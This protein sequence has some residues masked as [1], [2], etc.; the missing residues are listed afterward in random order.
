[1]EFDEQ[2][3]D[4]SLKH[5]IKQN[6]GLY[7]RKS[8]NVLSDYC[9]DRLRRWLNW[10]LEDTVIDDGENFHD[11]PEF[12]GP[13]AVRALRCVRDKACVWQTHC[14]LMNCTHT[15]RQNFITTA[16]RNLK[17]A[18]CNVQILWKQVLQHWF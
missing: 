14:R 11:V 12:P 4:N 17:T 10:P 5:Y 2:P 16:A 1:L 3:L 15:Q 9:T 8:I 7:K 13:T 18:Y 6:S